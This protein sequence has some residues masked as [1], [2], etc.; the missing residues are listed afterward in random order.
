MCEHKFVKGSKKDVYYCINCGVLSYKSIT[1]LSVPSL[2]KTSISLD[3]LL[4]KFKSSQFSI[5]F[6]NNYIIQYMSVRKKA[7]N[8]IKTQSNIFYFTKNIIYKAIN[9]L[10]LIYINNN[11]SFDLMPK[12]C[13]ICI[14]LAI[15]FNSCCTK[16]TNMDLQGFSYYLKNMTNIYETEVFCLKCL[17]YNLG[18][19]S[20]F[21]YIDLFFS[22]G[23]VFSLEKNHFD[24]SFIYSKCYECLELIIEDNYFLNFSSYTI[25][26]SLIKII[27]Q[28][29]GC[30]DN[31]IF[32][33]I[34]GINFNKD[35][36]LICQQYLIFL[37]SY[38][39]NIKEK[40]TL[41]NNNLQSITINNNK[42]SKIND[43]SIN[44]S[45][46]RSYCII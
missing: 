41:F 11:V 33:K 2:T 40:I 4:L 46:N 30:F 9:Y 12:I 38:N 13:I 36:Y 27:S 22:L 6:S 35:K 32:K 37:L 20:S 3:P 31:E 15:Q 26:L 19:Y 17:D 44:L 14:I 24:I 43:S 8:F 23:F 28:Y 42:E 34:Y 21:D 5:D 16:N 45:D 29:Y 39:F 10:D 25:T 7:I 18:L 1:S